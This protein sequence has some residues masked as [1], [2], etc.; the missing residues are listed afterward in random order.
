MSGTGHPNSHGRRA[1]RGRGC[2]EGDTGPPCAAL[3]RGRVQPCAF[4]C[5]PRPA[6]TPGSPGPGTWARCALRGCVQGL[7]GPGLRQGPCDGAEPQ[8]TMS[9]LDDKGR[10]GPA[11]AQG[12]PGLCSARHLPPLD[13]Q[14]DVWATLS[15]PPAEGLLPPRPDTGSHHISLGPNAGANGA[16]GSCPPAPVHGALGAAATLAG[17]RPAAVP[18]REAGAGVAAGLVLVSPRGPQPPSPHTQGGS[19]LAPSWLRAGLVVRPGW[20]DVSGLRA[21]P[22]GLVTPRPLWWPLE[23]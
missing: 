12:R 9:P 10:C 15:R 11:E 4:P 19:H 20:W 7:Q 21:K 6:P 13:P 17:R 1:R 18:P 23:T 14:E 3:R 2:G 16:L 5:P 8:G 22:L